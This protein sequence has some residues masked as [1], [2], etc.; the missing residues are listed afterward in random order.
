M[1]SLY[2][3]ELQDISELAVMELWFARFS[4]AEGFMSYVSVYLAN[5]VL[6]IRHL[7]TSLSNENM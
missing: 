4:A 1:W 5:R 2:V 3:T 6:T 7:N